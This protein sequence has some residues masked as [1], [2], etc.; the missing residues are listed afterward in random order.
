M[1][2]DRTTE[3][4]YHSGTMATQ[5]EDTLPGLGRPP[6]TRRQRRVLTGVAGTLATL[7]VVVVEHKW[8]AFAGLVHKLI[9]GLGL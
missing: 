1:R 8:P 3:R 6:R 9:E 7:V 2:V 5:D 4:V